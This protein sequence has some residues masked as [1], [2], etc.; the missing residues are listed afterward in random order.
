MCWAKALWDFKLVLDL[1]GLLLGL[2]FLLKEEKGP[3]GYSINVLVYLYVE[4][5][6]SNLFPCASLLQTHGRRSRVVPRS[7]SNVLKGFKELQNQRSFE[8]GFSDV[9][10]FREDMATPAFPEYLTKR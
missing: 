7:D 6:K 8:Y 5:G 10:R 2:I 4:M 1:A 3:G 9:E